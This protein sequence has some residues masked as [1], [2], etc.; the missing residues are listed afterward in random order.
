[1]AAGQS[2]RLY[3]SSVQ[4]GCRPIREVVLD[5]SAE[6]QKANQRGCTKL[7]CRKAAGQSER[8]YYTSVQKGSRPIREA[9][10]Y[11]TA[12]RLQTNQRG[13]TILQC[14]KAAGQSEKL[15]SLQCRKDPLQKGCGLINEAVLHR[16]VER[17]QA[18]QSGCSIPYS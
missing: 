14:R 15:Y 6:R 5:F 11:L 2:E 8:L 16:I 9:V 4:K 12:E 10:V 17:L 1:M 7:H 18:N 3:Y 13:C